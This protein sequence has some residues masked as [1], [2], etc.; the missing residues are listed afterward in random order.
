MVDG[1]RL[2][3]KDGF[4]NPMS[5]QWRDVW[6]LKVYVDQKITSVDPLLLPNCFRQVNPASATEPAANNHQPKN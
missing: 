5:R 3:A 2:N 4:L 1:V 6:F